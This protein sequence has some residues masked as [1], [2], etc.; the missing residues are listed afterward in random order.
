MVIGGLIPVI[1]GL[2]IGILFV[3]LFFAMLKPVDTMTDDELRELVSSQYPQFQALKERY[4]NTVVEEIERHD[5]ATE[6]RYV[7]TKEPLDPN[8]IS[9]P[10]PRIL[11]ITLEIQPLSAR[12]LSVICGSG[13][14]TDLPPTVQ[15]IKSTD[16][17]E[18]GV[19]EPDTSENELGGGNFDLN[20][21][22]KIYLTIAR[23]SDTY[24]QGEPI[25]FSVNAKGVSDNACNIGSPSVYMRDESN[26]GK[27][28]YWPNPFGFNTAMGCNGPDPIDKTWTYGDD[29]KSEIVLEKPGSYT[30]VAALEDVVIEKKFIVTS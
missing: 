7:A 23:F 10:G 2:A 30:L 29:A 25:I 6:F 11:A 17:L 1:A 27:I 15:T 5:R 16:C 13:L 28:I 14:T 9:F 21:I 24:K 4:P 3:A 19:F 18:V 8:I 20:N 12:T 26:D 22:N